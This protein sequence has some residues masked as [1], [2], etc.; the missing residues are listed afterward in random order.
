MRWASPLTSATTEVDMGGAVRHVLSID[1]LTDGELHWLVARG[2]DYASG[3]ALPAGRLQN[4][5]V[6]IWF[7]KTSTR[8]RT[9]FWSG[10]LRLGAQVVS[11]GP[12]DLQENTG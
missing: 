7:R 2:A 5:V 6:G 10:A 12:G 4:R 3:A 1:D 9:A 8:T 11:Y